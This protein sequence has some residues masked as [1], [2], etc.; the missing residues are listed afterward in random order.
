MFPRCVQCPCYFLLL[1][2]PILTQHLCGI[3]TKLPKGPFWSW[4]SLWHTHSQNVCIG[5]PSGLLRSRP[6]PNPQLREHTFLVSSIRLI[7]LPDFSLLLFFLAFPRFIFFATLS[8]SFR[9][10]SF[11]FS[12]SSLFEPHNSQRSMWF[13]VLFYWWENWYLASLT[14]LSNIIPK[15]SG[16]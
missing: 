1:S 16:T 4:Q 6:R 8:T 12:C 11:F 13:L 9:M 7:F 2:V 5:K 14:T 15:L 3:Y 10:C